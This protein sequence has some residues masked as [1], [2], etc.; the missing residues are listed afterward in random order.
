MS[1]YSF[2]GRE[3][4]ISDRIGFLAPDAAIIGSIALGAGVSVWFGAV[5]RGDN[6]P[7]VIGEGT[8]IQEMCMLHTDPGFPLT[9]G[10]GCTIG[11]RA[12]LHGCTI[13][14]NSLVGMGAIVLNGARIGVNCLIGAGALVTEN[15]EIP[16]N[17]LVIG[18]PAKVRRT[19]D[20]DAVR[21]LEAA[22]RGYQDKSG[23]FVRDLRKVDGPG[24]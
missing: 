17:S 18:S 12:I 11:H 24:R 7:I 16:D 4:S 14:G 5:M 2:E 15:T 9:I 1:I 10:A 3:P 20:Q 19:L 22:A 8:N 23:R 6:E 21:G 13:G